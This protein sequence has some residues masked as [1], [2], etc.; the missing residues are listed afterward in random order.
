MGTSTV[1]LDKLSFSSGLNLDTQSILGEKIIGASS[2]AV[3]QI[4]TRSSSNEIEF[5]YLNANKFALNET[6]TFKESM[7]RG[8]ISA[9]TK[10]SYTDKTQDFTLDKGQREQ[11]YDYSRIVRKSGASIPSR[12]LL[13]IFDYYTVPA[14]DTGDVYTVDSY[15]KAEMINDFSI[16]SS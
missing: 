8:A 3:G 5:V 11:Y 4:V 12:K 13:I 9:I 15:D 1:V 6:V 7:I 10:G 14:T 16:N 2:G